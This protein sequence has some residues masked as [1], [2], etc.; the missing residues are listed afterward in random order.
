MKLADVKSLADLSDVSK[1]E[2]IDLI[3]ELA[4]NLSMEGNWQF[5]E[6]AKFYGKV[7]KDRVDD[8]IRLNIRKIK[9]QGGCDGD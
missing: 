7:T 1:Q 3:T 8:I 2:L 6:T 5:D 4:S 9:L